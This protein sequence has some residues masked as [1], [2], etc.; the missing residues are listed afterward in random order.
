[1]T[2]IIL[3]ILLI[4]CVKIFLSEPIKNVELKN[5]FWIK[6]THQKAKFNIVVGGDSRIYRGISIDKL[7]E[8]LSQNLSGVNLGYSSIGFSGEYLD[9]MLSKLDLNSETKIMVLG[10]TPHSLT[11]NAAKNEAYHQYNDIN[12]D[13]RYKVLYLS[14]YTKHFAPYKPWELTHSIAKEKTTIGYFE[15]FT[16]SGWVASYKIPIDTSEAIASYTKTLNKHKISQEVIDELFLKIKEFEKSGITI[17]GFRV[18]STNQ[19]E[20]LEESLSSFNEE[21]LKDEF[22]RVGAFWF[23]FSNSDFNSYDGSHLHYLSAEKLSEKLGE[24]IS[25]INLQ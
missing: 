5:E 15:D 7:E 23:E 12:W 25:E 18:P 6:K 19:M 13:E 22:E 2:T 4:I 1:M 17:I 10:I 16:S 11:E 20:Q 3:S 21:Y 9:F 8:S 14:K 24:K